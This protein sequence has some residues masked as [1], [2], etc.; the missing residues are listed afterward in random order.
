MI[1]V[2][3]PWSRGGSLLLEKQELEGRVDPVQERIA[4]PLGVRVPGLVLCRAAGGQFC[5]DVAQSLSETKTSEEAAD[6]GA[7]FCPCPVHPPRT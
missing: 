4:L 7:N 2:S 1:R 5:W 3:L 6:Q